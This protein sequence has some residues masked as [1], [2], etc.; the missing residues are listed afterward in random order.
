M[1]KIFY[2][3]TI[4]QFKS[5]NKEIHEL[6]WKSLRFQDPQYFIKR[7]ITKG[8]MQYWDGF[9]DF[10][11]KKTGKFPSGIFPEIKKALNFMNIKYTIEDKRGP[12][13]PHTIINENF[14]NYV[15]LRDYQVEIAN[16][17]WEQERGIIKCP[18]GSGKTLIFTSIIKSIP[19]DMPALILFRSKTLVTQTYKIFEKHDVKNIGMIHGDVWKPNLK[20]L[21]TI[22]SAHHY[23]KLLDKF[24][25]L[26]VDEVH[27]FSKA[28]S[29]KIFK[30][31]TKARIRLGFSAT[32]WHKKDDVMKYKLKSW[33]GPIISD[34]PTLELQQKNI[35]SQS[36]CYF[37]KIS[38]PKYQDY[39]NYMEAYDNG[40]IHNQY[41]H[42]KVKQITDSYK[43]GRILIVVERIEHGCELIKYIPDSYWIQGSDKEEDRQIVI[44]KLT[45]SKPNEKI[46][47]IATRIMQT[48][49]DVKVHAVINCAGYKSFLMTIQRLGRGLRKAN[50]KKI[51]DYHD[52]YFE[53]CVDPILNKHSKQRMKDIENEGHQIKII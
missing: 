27:E 38:K 52:F 35:L 14:I 3:N 25:I 37:H 5:K 36:I 7:K 32:P 45:E 53:S 12:K 33:F 4:S 17:A 22:Q 10:Y 9:V 8:R 47:V 43:S 48:G 28:H 30:K 40:V 18:T 51:L 46:I 23:E 19:D 2:N 1:D 6:L 13:I 20:L 42:E 44:K 21:A 11:S 15:T 24:P 49:V 26:I 31:M 39:Y 29:I 16:M 34:I 50:D 41:M